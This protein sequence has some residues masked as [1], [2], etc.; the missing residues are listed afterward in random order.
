MYNLS[1]HPHGCHLICPLSVTGVWPVRE[2][3][4][5]WLDL[6]AFCNRCTTCPHTLTAAVSSSAS[7]STAQQS[8]PMACW[9]SSMSRQNVLCRTSMATMSSSTCWSTAAPRT[10]PRSST[11]STARSLSTAST[12]LPG[13]WD[14]CGVGECARSVGLLGSVPGR[15]AV[16]V[17]GS[18]PG[19][20]DCCGVGGVWNQSGGGWLCQ[21]F[22]ESDEAA[23]F[24][25]WEVPEC[26]DLN[27]QGWQIIKWSSTTKLGKKWNGEIW[28]LGGGVNGI[29][30]CW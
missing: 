1:T 24:L 16:A 26:P 13:Q 7:W 8:R 2:P 19:P 25:Q 12:S 23:D 18:V 11:A 28:L 9:R 6:S 27:A 17:L 22:G 21:R 3:L 4:R 20:W 30:V 14:C 15:L 10:S 29:C 5:L